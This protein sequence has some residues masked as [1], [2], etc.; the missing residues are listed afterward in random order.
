MN[1][2][3]RE[4]DV[5]EPGHTADRDDLAQREEFAI[6]GRHAQAFELSLIEDG[7]DEDENKKPAEISN[8]Q[9]PAVDFRVGHQVPE[10]DHRDQNG[11]ERIRSGPGK[12][13]HQAHFFIRR[14]FLN[15]ALVDD[16]TEHER[17]EKGNVAGHLHDGAFKVCVLTH[18]IPWIRPKGCRVKWLATNFVGIFGGLEPFV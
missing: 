6:L 10:G 16:S 8:G 9:K 2:D 1:S 17:S 18:D 15:R 4:H 5:K 13:V 3:G 7:V 12:T 14:Q 11:H